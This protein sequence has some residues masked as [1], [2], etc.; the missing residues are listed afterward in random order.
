MENDRNNWEAFFSTSMENDR[1]NWEAHLD[2][3]KNGKDNFFIPTLNQWLTPTT[4]GT[5]GRTVWAFGPYFDVSPLD[6]KNV[7]KEPLSLT[8]KRFAVAF[9]ESEFANVD[10]INLKFVGA[11]EAVREEVLTHYSTFYI[12]EDEGERKETKCFTPEQLRTEFGFPED[13]KIWYL[14]RNVSIGSVDNTWTVCF[15]VEIPNSLEVH[16]L[17]NRHNAN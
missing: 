7:N 12:M 11:A 6:L 2:I 10:S 13:E 4:L 9:E 17:I 15:T 16:L 3:L 1:N 14:I 8:T 5:P